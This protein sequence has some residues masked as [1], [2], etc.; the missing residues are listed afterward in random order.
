M[1]FRS[2]DQLLD[3]RLRRQ[4]AEQRHLRSLAGVREQQSDLEALRRKRLNNAG[5]QERMEG[6]VRQGAISRLELDRQQERNVE[7]DGLIHHTEQQQE[8]ARREL[9]ESEANVSQVGSG[10]RRQLN[11]I[12]SESRRQ[13]LETNTRLEQLQSRLQ[14][15][16]LRAPV[17]GHVLDLQAREGE[18]TS[19]RPLLRIEIGRAHV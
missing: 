9:A 16:V 8:A 10:N 17:A 13:L 5:I 1:L 18:L 15:A 14:L 2:Q 6:L 19:G 4:A 11:A 3:T 7:L 12:Y